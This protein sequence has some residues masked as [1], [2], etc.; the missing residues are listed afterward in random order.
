M[1]S[2][3]LSSV[4]RTPFQNNILEYYRMLSYLRPGILGDSEKKFEREYAKPI[5]DAMASNA[6]M[7]LKNFADEL[8]ESITAKV[9]PYVH[10]RNATV[11][12]NDLP[13]L[14]QVV[15]HVR[16]TKVQ[17]ALYALYR[18]HQKNANQS[19]FF[20]QYASLRPIHNHP[21][22][23]LFRSSEIEP[24]SSQQEKPRSKGQSTQPK[25][26]MK[27]PVLSSTSVKKENRENTKAENFDKKAPPGDSKR[28]SVDE[29]IDLMSDSEYEKEDMDEM[30]AEDSIGSGHWS[31]AVVNKMGAQLKDVNNGN[32]CVLLLHILMQAHALGEK[33]LVFSQSLKTLDF[34]SEVLAQKEWTSLV[35]S[36]QTSFPGRKMGGWRQGV[37]YLRIDGSTGSG[38]RG[39]LIKDFSADDNIKLFLISSLAGSLG[40]NLVSANRCVLFDSHFNPTIDFQAVYRMYRYGQ[41]KSCYGTKWLYSDSG[42]SRFV[43]LTKC[44][45]PPP[46]AMRNKSVYRFLTQGSME[47]KVY[48]RA[49]TKS[50]LAGRVIDGKTL[51]RIFNQ[52]ELDSLAKVDD[53]VECDR[54]K[55]WRMIPPDANVDVSKLPDV[56]NCEMMDEYDHRMNWT[57]D[58]PEKDAVW[59]NKH[60][61]KP[62]ISKGFGSPKE[63]TNGGTYRSPGLDIGPGKPLN[64]DSKKLVE[65][66]S[67]LKNLLD[68]SASGKQVVSK[69]Y[70]HDA[71]L[72]E[73]DAVVVK[74]MVDNLKNDT[75]P[76]AEPHDA[77][78]TSAPSTALSTENK[79]N[80]RD[81]VD[82]S[83]KRARLLF[84]ES[85]NSKE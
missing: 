41:T 75:T 66:D 33:T 32:K 81:E 31:A 23:I 34:L 14:Q 35:P 63:R 52:D 38:E 43:F 61:K 80:D 29:I 73:N 9:D 24:A 37:D 53:W 19:N 44:T 22:A 12:L 4:G 58:F 47:E 85:R 77:T 78:N 59:Y 72:S 15:L 7:S 45:F 83:Q 50:G 1:L 42:S 64:E 67:I 39:E 69:F 40:I 60:F 6:A 30:I 56:W 54:C 36:L 16:P 48:S 5:Y 70:F 27:G 49:V 3:L 8:L 2:Q 28:T 62:E 10:R 21:A 20:H 68:I 74:K 82:G 26:S 55:Q 79:R 71:L 84:P 51:H 57:C 25:S 18:K 17:R 46:F 13:S 76:R 11:L 65:R